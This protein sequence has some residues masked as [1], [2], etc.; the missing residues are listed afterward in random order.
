MREIR[1]QRSIA[2]PILFKLGDALNGFCFALSDQDAIQLCDAIRVV[3]EGPT[4]ADIAGKNVVVM[5]WSQV[6]AC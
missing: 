5:K 6:N 4:Q 2:G 3:V 1:V